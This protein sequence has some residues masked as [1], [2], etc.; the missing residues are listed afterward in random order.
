MLGTFLHT[1]ERRVPRAVR[2][3]SNALYWLLR[4]RVQKAIAWGVLYVEY[5]LEKVLHTIRHTT[6]THTTK[7]ASP[8]LRE[9]AEH[10]RNLLERADKEKNAIYEE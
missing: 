9:V 8:F 1:V 10:K 5:V 3:G 6:A 4:R 2:E 7:E